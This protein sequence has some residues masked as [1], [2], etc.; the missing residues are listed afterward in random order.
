MV[1]VRDLIAAPGRFIAALRGGEARAAQYFGGGIHGDS[2]FTPRTNAGEYVNPE[3]SLQVVPVLA[4]VSVIAGTM[5]TLP[6]HVYKRLPGGG[7]AKAY[8]HPLYQIL[9]DAVNPLLT[10]CEFREMSQAHLCL[11]GNSYARIYRNGAGQ[12]AALEP[13]HPDRV[14]IFKDGLSVTYSVQQPQGGQIVLRQEEVLHIR[15]LG[16]EGVIGYSPITLARESIGLTMAAERHGANIFGNGARPSGVLQYDKT[17][18]KEQLAQLKEEWN[19]T[20][21]GDRSGGTAVLQGGVKFS[22]VSMTAEDAQFLETRQYQAEEVAR[23]FRVPPHKIGIMKNATFSNIEHQSIEFV[24]D[25]IRPWA[26]RQEQRMNQTLLTPTERQ[27]YFIEYNLEGLLRGDQKSRFESYRIGLDGGFL[28]P[29]EVRDFENL[30][31]IPGGDTY[32][33]PMNMAK[34]GDFSSSQSGN[35]AGEQKV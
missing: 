10:S 19:A 2:G 11:R 33:M 34:L 7:K 14:S 18:N 31:P 30:N 24:T 20:N 23:L 13:L 29:D 6:L 21:G 17:L 5:G 9:H 3:N 27:T 28:S 16:S 25:C 32:R 12:V 15:G 4:C 1:K 26:V 35:T 8:E 22:G